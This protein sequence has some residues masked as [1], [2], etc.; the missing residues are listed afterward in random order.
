[1][2]LLDDATDLEK[3][4]AVSQELEVTA[5]GLQVSKQTMSH[6]KDVFSESQLYVWNEEFTSSEHFMQNGREQQVL[7]ASESVD[8][9]G[10]LEM[11]SRKVDI[12]LSNAKELTDYFH[13]IHYSLSAAF[14]RLRSYN[15]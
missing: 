12:V 14:Y 7:T 13:I 9:A 2:K 6:V 3:L 5:V 8:V 15:L 1:M 11:A 10:L 4:C